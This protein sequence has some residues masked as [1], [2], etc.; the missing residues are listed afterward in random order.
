[1]K[2]ALLGDIA[3][4]GKNSIKKNSSLFNYYK[5]VKCY[6]ADYDIVIANLET[7]FNDSSKPYGYK[8]AYIDSDIENV[9]I[10]KYLGV[11]IVNLAN[12]H[13]GR[14]HDAI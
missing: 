7:P 6:L 3:F 13:I 9:E 8:S 1:M 14:I 12:N 2:I 5:D 10:L 4:F 11:S